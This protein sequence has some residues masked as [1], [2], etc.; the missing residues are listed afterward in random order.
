VLSRRVVEEVLKDIE[1]KDWRFKTVPAGGGVLITVEFDRPDSLTGIM[2]TSKNMRP[3]VVEQ[4][5]SEGYLINTVYK[6]VATA[7]EHEMRE[8]FKYK[9][10]PRFSPHE[11]EVRG[12]NC[13]SCG[14]SVESCNKLITQKMYPCCSACHTRDTH[15]LLGGRSA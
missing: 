1:Y 9:G 6:A 13:D 4:W 11:Q 2:G 5:R 12:Q 8:A 15:M 10:K 14:A 7:E 3:W